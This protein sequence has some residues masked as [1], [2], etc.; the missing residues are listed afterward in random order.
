MDGWMATRHPP[1]A[2]GDAAASYLLSAG[3][4]RSIDQEE[5]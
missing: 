2:A 5:E 1:P 3:V 4:R